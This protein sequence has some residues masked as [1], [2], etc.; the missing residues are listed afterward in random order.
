MAA[1]EI[2]RHKYCSGAYIEATLPYIPSNF[3]PNTESGAPDAREILSKLHAN[4][5]GNPIDDDRSKWVSGL[6]GG[7]LKE[8]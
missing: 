8:T 5:W 2:V 4:F 1:F 6:G 3:D 7:K